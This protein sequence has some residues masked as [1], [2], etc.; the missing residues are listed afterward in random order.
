[1]KGKRNILERGINITPP[2]FQAQGRLQCTG[3]TQRERLS[4]LACR[5]DVYSVDSTYVNGTVCRGRRTLASCALYFA[6]I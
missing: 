6:F 5:R 3:E 1:M 4:N 2:D